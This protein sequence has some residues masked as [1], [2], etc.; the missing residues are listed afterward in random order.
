MGEWKEVASRGAFDF[1]VVTRMR[2]SQDGVELPPDRDFFGV[3][4]V[5]GQEPTIVMFEKMANVGA[6]VRE[7]AP[8]ALFL[9]TGADEDPVPLQRALNELLL[10]AGDGRCESL[11]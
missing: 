6:F 10:A 1:Q 11:H 9:L 8:R 4:C 7:M 2:A 3:V 5:D